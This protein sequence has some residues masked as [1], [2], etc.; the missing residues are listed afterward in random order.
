MRFFSINEARERSRRIKK[1]NLKIT[2]EITR[3]I[4]SSRNDV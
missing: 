1:R 3:T 4:S 2:S